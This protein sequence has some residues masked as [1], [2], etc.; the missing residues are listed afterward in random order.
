MSENFDW[1]KY[2]DLLP[3]VIARQQLGPFDTTPIEKLPP[4]MA[5]GNFAE[6]YMAA[7]A[8]RQQAQQTPVPRRQLHHQIDDIR[9]EHN[10]AP[11]SM[12]EIAKRAKQDALELD[13]IDAQWDIID[14]DRAIEKEILGFT[15]STL[16]PVETP[17]E[18]KPAGRLR[19]LGRSLLEGLRLTGESQTGPHP[20]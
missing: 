3:E 10:I 18:D 14:I 16:G 19:R 11:P 12:R 2:A 17:V 15:F 7:L 5:R 13:S 6:A 9:K 20:I 1:S 4:W 8:T